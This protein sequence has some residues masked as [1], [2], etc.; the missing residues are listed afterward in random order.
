M[1]ESLRAAVVADKSV[2]MRVTDEKKHGQYCHASRI[3]I[4]DEPDV[5][6]DSDGDGVLDLDDDVPWTR[7]R[8]SIPTTTASA[9]MRTPMTI[10]TAF[11]TRMTHSP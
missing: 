4:Q 7:R 10:T 5:D 2:E 9:T 11:P 8:R 1:F 3:K 6:E